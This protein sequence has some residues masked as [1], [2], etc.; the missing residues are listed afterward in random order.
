[1]CDDRVAALRVLNRGNLCLLKD[2]FERLWPVEQAARFEE[3]LQALD[4]ADEA[5]SPQ[6][7][8]RRA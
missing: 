5:D 8:D 2:A 6:D 4:E 7:R 1:M 3:L